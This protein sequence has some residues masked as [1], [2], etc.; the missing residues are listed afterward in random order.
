MKKIV[1]IVVM[2]AVMAICAYSAEI[3]SREFSAPKDAYTVGDS[4]VYV[5]TLTIATDEAC[6]VDPIQPPAHLELEL[7]TP[8]KNGTTF[9]ITSHFRYFDP[10]ITAM[11]DITV[12]CTRPNKKATV[13]VIP[14][15]PI[16]SQSVLTEEDTDIVA[17][18]PPK[19][20]LDTAYSFVPLVITVFVIIGVVLLIIWLLKRWKHRVRAQKLPE[21]WE[22]RID[23]LEYIRTEW[24]K[25]SIEKC[26]HAHCE[27]EL[28]YDV[29][30][31]LRT[32]LS[33]EYKKN[34]ID[35]TTR[36][37][38]YNF[39][40]TLSKQYFERLCA[41]L[42]YADMVKFAKVE[43]SQTDIDDVPRVMEETITLFT[44]RH[45]ATIPEVQ[46]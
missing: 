2:L 24:N 10:S 31:I 22:Q 35:M 41:F 12:R 40:E 46:K 16:V 34:Y 11:P 17:I 3:S 21:I 18:R 6:T 44:A 9:V 15:L 8:E 14:G 20:G 27:K 36:E 43:P 26:I 28:Y 29:T 42:E 39:R 23:P 25:I 7:M 5:V 4:I 33:L 37:F 13:L 19:K 45:A 30:E 38:R 1:T 32:F